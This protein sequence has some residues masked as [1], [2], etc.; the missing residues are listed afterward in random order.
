[1][2]SRAASIGTERWAAHSIS[3][4]GAAC[5]VHAIRGSRA[6]PAD[7]WRILKH[8]S[9]FPRNPDFRLASDQRSDNNCIASVR[10]Q[11]AAILLGPL[12]P[13]VR[14]AALACPRRTRRL[15]AMPQADTR[16]EIAFDI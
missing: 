9:L 7:S 14:T 11:L 16:H 2:C 15:P 5:P 13:V 12:A 10:R 8:F 4:N 6:A 1:M 3:L